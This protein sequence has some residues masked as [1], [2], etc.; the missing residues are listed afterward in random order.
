MGEGHVNSTMQMDFTT[1]PLGEGGM[2]E[3]GG[4]KKKEKK[5]GTYKMKPRALVQ[6]ASSSALAD[7]AK[8]R[9]LAEED[10]VMVEGNKQKLPTVGSDAGLR[11]QSRDEQ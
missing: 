6:V 9:P 1:Q 8:K 4:D 5:L 2:C 3:D 11:I 7:G 10:E